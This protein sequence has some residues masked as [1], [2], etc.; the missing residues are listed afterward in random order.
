MQR[1]LSF[2]RSP[3]RAARV[4]Q[5][6]CQLPRS[7]CSRMTGVLRSRPNPAQ[8][9][10]MPCPRADTQRLR[11]SGC[12]LVLLRMPPLGP[13]RREKKPMP[14]LL[15]PQVLQRV[16]QRLVVPRSPIDPAKFWRRRTCALTP[17]RKLGFSF[18]VLGGLQLGCMVLWK[19]TRCLSACP[20][21]TVRPVRHC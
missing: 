1:P 6:S 20:L 16:V 19:G 17:W 21:A 13:R 12:S 11:G 3:S 14:H 2:A 9:R 10:I 15:R 18:L 7:A 4:T 8:L 5:Q